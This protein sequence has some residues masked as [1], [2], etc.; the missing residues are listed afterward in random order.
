MRHSFLPIEEQKILKRGYRSHL[1]I[2][3]LFMFSVVGL[4]GV[5]SLFPAYM[6]VSAERQNAEKA[7]ASLKKDKDSSGSAS[8]EAEL[9][10]DADRLAQF[11]GLE[12][13]KRPSILF[14][15]IL[16]LRG[17]TRVT[18]ISLSDISTT[19]ATILVQG[20]AP[21]RESL[22]TLKSRLEGLNPGSKISLPISGFAKN[23]DIPF[24]LKVTQPIK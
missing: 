22:L 13:G 14:A 21:T 1:V 7:L 19:T 8:T 18:S 24:S 15:G 4:I 17:Q 9:S 6:S 10:A 16:S 2:T 23:K 11:N 12:N 5:G 20:V 3:A